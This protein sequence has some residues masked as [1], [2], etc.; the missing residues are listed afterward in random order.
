MHITANDYGHN[1]IFTLIMLNIE[2]IKTLQDEC[3][4]IHLQ[5]KIHSTNENLLNSVRNNDQHDFRY[6]IFELIGDLS[7]KAKSTRYNQDILDLIKDLTNLCKF[8]DDLRNVF[9]DS[10]LILLADFRGSDYDTYGNRENDKI[11]AFKL[12]ENDYT[13]DGKLLGNIRCYCCDSYDCQRN[14][15]TVVNQES[16]ETDEQSTNFDD[17]DFTELDE[18]DFDDEPKAPVGEKVIKRESPREGELKVGIKK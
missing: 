9:Y 2:S 14:N 5:D 10:N 16:D 3:Y 11:V 1:S 17:F 4:D 7:E 18:F 8:N 12:G 13:A 15:N 6:Y